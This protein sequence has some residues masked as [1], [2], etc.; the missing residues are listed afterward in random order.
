MTPYHKEHIQRLR[1]EGKGYKGI[2]ALLGL[3]ENTVKSFCKRNSFANVPS[4]TSD[5]GFVHI[6]DSSFCKN[7]GKPIKTRQ[8]VKPRKFCCDNCRLYW[9]NKHSDQVTQ[10][11]IYH[12]VCAG[13]GNPF[14]SYGNKNRKYCTH[15]CYIKARFRS[16]VI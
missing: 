2:A 10:K 12:M 7:C 4:Y 6:G 15:S 11:A 5:N 16:E 9:W 14:D 13:C 8:G 3:S 1:N